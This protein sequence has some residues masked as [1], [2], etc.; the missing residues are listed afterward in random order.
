MHAHTHRH[1]QLCTHMQIVVF[2]PNIT[3][4]KIVKHVEAKVKEHLDNL[5]ADKKLPYSIIWP[6]KPWATFLNI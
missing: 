2:T 1:T 4:G 3:M 5:V 6:L